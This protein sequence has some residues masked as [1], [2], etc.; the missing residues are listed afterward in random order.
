[1]IYPLLVMPCVILVAFSTMYG[2][3][4]SIAVINFA[5][6]VMMS[7]SIALGIDYC[8]FLLVRVQEGYKKY[9]DIDAAIVL[10]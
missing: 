4:K 6:Q 7:L 5:P 3:T 9:G 10:M 2:V 8:M 1:M